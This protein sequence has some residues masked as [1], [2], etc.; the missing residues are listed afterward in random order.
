MYIIETGHS[1]ACAGIIKA[2]N[3]V[4]HQQ[5]IL[6]S[7]TSLQEKDLALLSPNDTR[8]PRVVLPLKDCPDGRL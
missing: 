3:K 2:Y 6:I 4:S 8:L 1:R 5:P 7:P